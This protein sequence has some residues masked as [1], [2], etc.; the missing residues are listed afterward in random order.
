VLTFNSQPNEKPLIF[1]V[2]L[3]PG[4]STWLFGQPYGNTTGAYNFGTAWYSSGQGLHFGIDVG[5][6]CGTP[7][8]AVADG[9]VAAVD[10]LNFGS[11]P[12]NL[13]L[14]HDA[15]GIASLYGHLRERPALAPGQTVT[16]GQVIAVSGDPDVTCDSRPH[17][18]FEV[19]SL[20]YWTT[21][22]PVDYID[23]NWHNLIIVGS[24]GYPLFQGDM[25]NARRWMTLE[26]QPP[27]RFGG[28]R[29]NAYQTVFP[30]PQ[31]ERPASNAPLT[32]DLPPLLEDATW[33]A[34][35]IGVGTC[36]WFKWWHPTDPDVLYT[37]DGAEGARAAIFAWSAERGEVEAVVG[38]TPPAFTSP[39]GT[40]QIVRENGKVYVVK[41]EERF[42]IESDV[43]T[44]TISTDNSRLMWMLTS[45]VSVPGSP[46]PAATIWVSD[47]DGANTR[48]IMSAPGV[49]AQ[50]LDD[51]RLL[52]TRPGDYRVT[53][54]IIYN[55]ADD[56]QYE[57]G[58]WTWLRHLTVAPGGGRL[59][60]YIT[61][62]TNP[63]DAGIYTIETMP[64]AK[65]QKIEWF[66]GWRWR[67]GDSLYYIPLDINAEYQT[68]HYYH[69]P[70]GEDR[71]LTDEPFIV[72][73]SDW[74]VS[75]DGR[76]ILFHNA[77]DRELWLLEY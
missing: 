66:G 74:Q 58:A 30:P 38:T 45:G 15:L 18:H 57:L 16:K 14:R 11:G 63:D 55:T 8:V 44:P 20:D 28:A 61:N 72:M 56:S 7:L 6:P 54:L 1:P 71:V 62:Q 75:A 46:R 27:V 53:T 36:C 10:N 60:F 5:M 21:Y 43:T 4:P 9:Q 47:L 67:D 69:I 42:L 32:R 49:S 51:S 68:L 24:Y 3:P 17:L 13:I 41:D 31:Q 40:Y 64:D 19:R 39:D 22:N 25:D 52:I 59:L 35:K 37:I 26:D 34:R 48:Q 29:L 76:R 33:S 70:T 2:D 12:H 23:I 77:L 73:N 50:W 65:A